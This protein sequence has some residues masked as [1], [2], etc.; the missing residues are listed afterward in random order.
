MSARPLHAHATATAT[1]GARSALGGTTGNE[2]LTS[3]T[4]AV[5]TLLLAAEGIT[6]L[7]LGQLRREHMFIGL[8][9]L[10]PV[11]LKMGSTG[12][13]FA[14]YY[15]GTRAYREK[16]PP[17]LPLRLVAPVL[18]AA[19][20]GVFATGVA[21]LLVGHRSGLLLTLHKAT[22]IVWGASFAIH[23]LAHLPRMVGALRRQT[24]R[25]VAGS[26][27]RMGLVAGSLAG[28]LV[29]A[30]LLV[31]SITGWDGGYR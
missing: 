6:I 13:R 5:L 12:Y 31:S 16:G 17:I 15:A 20:V 4:A 7:F 22:F 3:T 30:L 9:L 25:A 26:A 10:G 8:V 19:T 24:T 18:V 28:G 14:R 29:L 2:L 23:F 27:A 11:A 1:G 21:L